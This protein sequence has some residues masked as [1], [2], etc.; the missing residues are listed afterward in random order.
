MRVRLRLTA[1]LLSV[2][3]PGL[4]LARW[5]AGAGT[6]VGPIP[7]PA[8]PSH[9]GPW[10]AK[11]EQRLE[12]KALA[13]IKPDAHVIRLYEA[14]GRTPVWIYVGIYGGRAGYASG[15]HDPHVCYRAQGWQ[16]LA[17]SSVEVPLGTSDRMHTTLLEVHNANRKQE[18]L[19][20]FQPAG[21]WPAAGAAEELIRVFDAVA[22]RPQY[23]FV[24]LSGSSQIGADASRD[25]AEFAGGIAPAIRA[26]LEAIGGQGGS[27]GSQKEHDK[28]LRAAR[29]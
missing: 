6:P 27:A 19:Y 23:A 9:V 16:V 13:I 22:G 7:T 12:P 8:L 29:R 2:L 3:V 28:A 18:V 14:P 10:I 5:T 21:R 25:L 4:L 20:W 17:S 26:A 11:A 15:A 1:A 24:R